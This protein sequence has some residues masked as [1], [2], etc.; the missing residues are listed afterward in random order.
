MNLIVKC[1]FCFSGFAVHNILTKEQ[2]P[3]IEKLITVHMDTDLITKVIHLIHK[4]KDIFSNLTS[5]GGFL[6][7][8]TKAVISKIKSKDKEILVEV[9][10][11]NASIHKRTLMVIMKI[12]E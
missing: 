2:I 1:I 12:N 8:F 3:I 6:V 11:S 10:K 7:T 4:F 5:F 9:I